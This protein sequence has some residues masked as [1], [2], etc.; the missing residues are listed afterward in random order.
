MYK[1]Q[2]LLSGDPWAW[3]TWLARRTG[4]DPIAIWEWGAI[5]RVST[6]LLLCSIGMT[7]IG[8]AMWRAAEVAAAGPPVSG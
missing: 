5:E 3:T 6:G 4:T 2:H 8:T 7:D 1:R